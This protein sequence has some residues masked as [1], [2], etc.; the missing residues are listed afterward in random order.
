MG[1]AVRPLDRRTH[2]KSNHATKSLPAP[3]TYSSSVH[4]RLASLPR[5]M[6]ARCVRCRSRALCAV[7][8]LGRG[9]ATS[10]SCTRLAS[11]QPL[12]A[13]SHS[14]P[15]KLCDGLHMSSLSFARTMDSVSPRRRLAIPM[16]CASSAV[17]VAT[18]PR[19]A[20]REHTYRHRRARASAR[21]KERDKRP[22]ET[23]A[24][25]Q[26][27]VSCSCSSCM[28]MHARA[29]ARRGAFTLRETSLMRRSS[30]CNQSDCLHI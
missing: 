7:R 15:H 2:Y 26:R 22:R 29:V 27:L 21:A 20:A 23:R 10:G 30:A 3:R 18:C 9:P 25:R 19:Q 6:R 1:F 14:R 13:R 5:E 16:R 24:C 17:A 4:T 28:C 8:E 12:R 11:P